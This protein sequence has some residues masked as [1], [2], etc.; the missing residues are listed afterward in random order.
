MTRLQML[1]HVQHQLSPK[2]NAPSACTDSFISFLDG[3]QFPSSVFSA[4]CLPLLSCLLNIQS[5][6]T[7]R[8]LWIPAEG[9]VHVCWLV[10]RGKCSHKSAGHNEKC[11]KHMIQ[12]VICPQTTNTIN[13][14][15]LSW[16]F[17]L[18]LYW[19]FCRTVTASDGYAIFV[20]WLHSSVVVLAWYSWVD[21]ITMVLCTITAKIDFV[22]VF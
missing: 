5:Q 11:S 22:C 2:W 16:D 14:H 8:S 7:V 10:L 18:K 4:G 13:H 9:I 1:P 15:K 3:I 17:S 21:D 19:W 6:R 12:R 20:L